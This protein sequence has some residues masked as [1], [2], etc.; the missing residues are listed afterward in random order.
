M[1]LFFYV[2]RGFKTFD[3]MLACVVVLILA[4]LSVSSYQYSVNK[5]HIAS[6]LSELM[7]K[8]NDAALFYQ[9]KGFW[10]DTTE[11]TLWDRF[12]HAEYQRNE[13]RYTYSYTGSGSFD[14]HG[15]FNGKNERKSVISYRWAE[16]VEQ[17]SLHIMWLCGFREMAVQGNHRVTGENRTD[18]Y[19]QNLL[20]KCR[21]Q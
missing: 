13:H 2:Q 9:V 6:A 17:G 19:V 18:T 7:G 16:P 3:F 21:K 15:Y 12:D 10:P 4:V 8:R 5:A 1:G 14:I 11:E 20:S